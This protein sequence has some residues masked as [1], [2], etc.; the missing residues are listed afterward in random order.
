LNW[1]GGRIAVEYNTS[2]FTA[3]NIECKGGVGRAG[4]QNGTV[5]ING[6]QL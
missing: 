6:T 4:G 5:V 1:G 3:D 2:T